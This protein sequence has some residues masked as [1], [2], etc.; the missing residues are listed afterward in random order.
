MWRRIRL[1][2]LAASVV[3]ALGGAFAW[4]QLH[5]NAGR[6]GASTS[7]LVTNVAIGGPFTLTD[8]TGRVVTD[9]D[10]RG[11]LMLVFFGYT[12]CPDVCPTEL[13]DVALTLDELGADAKAVKPVFITIDPER[14]TTEALADYVPLFHESLVG[15]TGTTEQVEEVARSY[16][17]FYRKVEDPQY[18]YYLMDHTSF[19]YLMGRDG[20]FLSMFAYGTAPEKMAEAIRGH[21]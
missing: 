3:I 10:Y 13:G 1:A 14:D 12:F 4:W 11:R 20:N 9:E 19:V 21:I 16:R 5:N 8:H 2:T 15:L 6:V 17:V 7:G 18:T